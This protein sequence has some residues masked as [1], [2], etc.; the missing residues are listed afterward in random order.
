MRA[1]E[2]LLRYVK[3]NTVSDEAKEGQTPSTD[4]QRELA[5]LL[6]EE[7]R[8]IGVPEVYLDEEHAYVYG[9]FPA[10]SGYEDGKAI[11]FIAHLDTVPFGENEVKPQII[12]NYQ[13]GSIALGESG[14]VLKPEELCREDLKGKCLITTDGTS[15]L[16]A[17]DKA[18]VAEIMTLCEKLAE[19]E[20]LHGPV[21]VCFTPDEEIG[22]GAALLDLKRL[23]AMYAY[24][25]DGSAPEEIEYETFHAA[26]AVWK[27]KG[28]SIHPGSAKGK[29]VNAALLAM[30]I[31]GMLPEREIPRETSGREGF[32]HLTEIKGDVPKAEM[33]YII[34]DHDVGQFE[35]RKQK[36]LE[37]EKTINEKYQ[38]QAVSVTIMEQYRNMAEVLE[39]YPEVLEA[40]KTAIQKAG[41]VPVSNPVRGGTDGAQL[42]FRG[43]PCPNL[44][45]GS[46][47]FHGPYEFAVAEQ[48]DTV[49][50]ILGYLVEEFAKK[51]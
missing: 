16:G 15:V 32:Y 13:G 3:I 28:N 18:G 30:E 5:H 38:T 19:G 49:V 10:S 21:S 2:R 42:S 34:R 11:A 47:G 14:L 29:M 23:G 4:C 50:Q 6:E 12:E 26:K 37:I 35:K 36:M 17:D 31:N 1:Y 7:L 48:M 25:V 45:N 27:I 43:L 41:L 46:Y 24:T 33:E 44:G 40:A 20:L 22:H 39:R 51:R 9:K 8:E